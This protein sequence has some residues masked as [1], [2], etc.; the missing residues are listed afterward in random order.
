MDQMDVGSRS[1]VGHPPRSRHPRLASVAS[2]P[3]VPTPRRRSWLPCSSK[4]FQVAAHQNRALVATRV[5]SRRGVV[6]YAGGAAIK[7][8]YR[9]VCNRSFYVWSAIQVSCC[10]TYQ[11]NNNLKERHERILEIPRRPR[12]R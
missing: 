2:S 3:G 9:T 7:P 11:D 1:E 8:G 5:S 10:Y 4:N 6:L 12:I